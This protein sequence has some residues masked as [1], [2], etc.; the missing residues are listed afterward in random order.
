MSVSP[1]TGS[2]IIS[3]HDYTWARRTRHAFRLLVATVFL[4]TFA[5]WFS[6]GYLRYDKSETQY[7]MALTLHPAQARPILRAVVAREAETGALPASKY[8][9]ALAFVEE[10][11]RI[12]PAYDQAYAVNSR[13]AFLIINYGCALYEDGQYEEARER[14]REA[15][16]NPPRNALPRY[17]E[18][19]ARAASMKPED[20]LS[21]LI[22]LLTRANASG[23][24]VL[25]PEP[26]WHESLPTGG[27]RY[28]ETRLA[29][30]ERIT[31]PLLE[32]ADIIFKRALVG[33]EQEE[34]QN[35]DNW[36]AN[37]QTMGERLMGARKHD[38]PP[39]APQ[40]IAAIEMQLE[41]LRLRRRASELDGGVAAPELN[42]ALLRLEDALGAVR[43]FEELQA[44]LLI[45]QA[46]RLFMP[47]YLI[48]E[49]TLLFLLAY[50]L[51]WLLHYVGAG[52]KSARA[53]PHIWPGRFAP[54]A[55]LGLMLG[56]LTALMI[57]HNITNAAPWEACL[58]HLW[59]WVI[60]LLTLFG[61]VYPPLLLKASNLSRVCHEAV[62]N[63]DACDANTTRIPLR[64]CI[65]IYGCLL[66]RYMG[67][68][69]GGFVIT[70]CVW[71]ALYRVAFSV[72]PFQM[73]LITTG[74]GAET[75]HLLSQIQTIL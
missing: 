41:A 18:A 45:K 23:D 15:G 61:L 66:R 75:E 65:G 67:V 47:V 36:L 10:A 52:G 9:E 44:R 16:V 32:C 60:A 8:I 22:A 26:L 50:A 71:L 20:D 59:R 74:V 40:L 29:I 64:R 54:V 35:W 38:S 6:E 70:L 19:A 42:D 72:Y 51:G 11:D 4:L 17:L 33:I 48:A 57:A 58:A 5:L 3:V 21:D 7:R 43:D 24:P 39:T 31:A 2:S 46:E 56:I 27:R 68:L 28:F 37:T 53:I 69:C 63:P 62:D 73:E 34:Q 55:G 1:K 12:L 13:N 49:A 14:F 25:F 30:S